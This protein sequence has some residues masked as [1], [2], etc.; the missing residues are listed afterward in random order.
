MDPAQH[1][2]KDAMRN[3]ETCG[4]GADGPPTCGLVGTPRGRNR[5]KGPRG[6]PGDEPSR[7]DDSPSESPQSASAEVGRGGGGGAQSPHQSTARADNL[8]V[9][10][11]T[12]QG[13]PAMFHGCQVCRLTRVKLQVTRCRLY[14]V[15]DPLSMPAP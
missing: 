15:L 7:C 6:A 4:A 2:A 11:T 10:L 8:G 1:R 13:H 5:C 3:P 9:G 12:D 14:I